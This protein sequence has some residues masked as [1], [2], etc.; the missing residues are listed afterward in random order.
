M[1]QSHTGYNHNRGSRRCIQSVTRPYRQ[2]C[3]PEHDVSAK[4][5]VP[6]CRHRQRSLRRLRRSPHPRSEQLAEA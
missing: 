2:K 3:L 1:R 4:T 6:E 5:T